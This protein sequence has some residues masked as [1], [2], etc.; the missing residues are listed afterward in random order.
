MGRLYY[1]SPITAMGRIKTTYGITWGDLASFTWDNL[2]ATYPTWDSFGLLSAQRKVALGNAAGQ[3][4]LMGD[5]DGS[6]NGSPIEWGFE[7]PLR[8]WAG[9]AS[10]FV[11]STF[12]TFF[13]QTANSTTLNTSL[14][15]SDTL[16]SD[17]AYA[18]MATVDLATDQ[19]NDLDVSSLG[20]KRFVSLKHYGSA[21]RGQIEWNGGMFRGEEAKIAS[22][23][24]GG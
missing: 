16:M 15:Y 2:A 18:V 7:L 19:R 4:F 24:T 21:S 6:D 22:G 10:N 13:K 12:E 9:W 20:E 5:G 17:P 3:V 8:S 23:P 14:G 1:P 11:P